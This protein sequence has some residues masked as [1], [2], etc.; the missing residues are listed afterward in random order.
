MVVEL[1]NVGVCYNIG[2]V[3]LTLLTNK[4]LVELGGDQT[5]QNKVLPVNGQGITG[6]TLSAMLVDKLSG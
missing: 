4:L 6:K 5:V 1:G 3:G 2:A